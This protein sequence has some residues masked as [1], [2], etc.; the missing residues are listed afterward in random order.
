MLAVPVM[1][2][3]TQRSTLEDRH[4]QKSNPVTEA[5]RHSHRARD[6]KPPVRKNPEVKAKHGY[7]DDRECRQVEV[8]IEVVD[9]QNPRDVLEGYFPDVLAESKI[10]HCRDSQQA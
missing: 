8:L 2:S 3:I 10:G 6:L 5:G 9:L 1:P 4:Q 7:F